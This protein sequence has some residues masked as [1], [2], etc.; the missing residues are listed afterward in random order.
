M[1]VWRRLHLSLRFEQSWQMIYEIEET[2]RR[3]IIAWILAPW[4]Y[5][6]LRCAHPLIYARN[7]SMELCWH[8]YVISPATFLSMPY[9]WQLPDDKDECWKEGNKGWMHITG[10]CSWLCLY[11]PPKWGVVSC[12]VWDWTNIVLSVSACLYSVSPPQAQCLLVYSWCLLHS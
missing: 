3:L 5:L 8:F 12:F 6:F 1:V 4:C 11:V 10:Y 2:K 9:W 7:M